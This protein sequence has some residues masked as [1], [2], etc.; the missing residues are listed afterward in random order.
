MQYA[1]GYIFAP[2]YS[3][4]YS[5]AMSIG[6]RLDKAMKGARIDSQSELARKSGVP[7]ATIS[8]ILKGTGKKGPETETIK[9]LA[10]ACGVTFEYLNEGVNGNH[11]T[12]ELRHPS[13]ADE[14]AKLIV[15]YLQLSEKERSQVMTL[16]EG[17]SGLDIGGAKSAKH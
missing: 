14:I 17:L 12:S 2:P 5:F 1:N 7:Q 4:T 15:T 9:R 6:D 16:M 13:N 10:V 8:R 3:E 11:A